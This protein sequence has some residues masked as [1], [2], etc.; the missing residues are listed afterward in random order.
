MP[1]V[2]V[3]PKEELHV[4]RDRQ[5]R[6]SVAHSLPY[7]HLLSRARKQAVEGLCASKA[8]A[9]GRATGVRDLIWY[10]FVQMFAGLLLLCR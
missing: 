7:K 3:P 6:G 2:L 10:Y 9:T 1:E 8:V 4:R 5:G